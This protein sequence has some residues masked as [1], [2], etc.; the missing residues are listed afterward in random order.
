[1]TKAFR[2]IFIFLIALTVQLDLCFAAKRDVQDP[3]LRE[4]INEFGNKIQKFTNK[5]G[6]DIFNQEGTVTR[7]EFII[8]LYEYDIATQAINKKKLDALE[9]KVNLLG[10]ND[11]PS[12]SKRKEK[13]DATNIV[14][15]I[16]D[17]EPNM[18]MLLDNSLKNSKVFNELQQQIKDKKGRN[19]DTP[20]GSSISRK[21][22]SEIKEALSR[23]ES[24]QRSISQKVDEFKRIEK[25]PVKELSEIKKTLS[26]LQ[27]DYASILKKVD[28]LN[29]STS[30]VER[31]EKNKM[32]NI[33]TEYNDFSSSSSYNNNTSKLVGLS[34]GL[35][36]V[37]ALFI[38]RQ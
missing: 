8:A 12:N 35:S 28:K 17:L 25:N 4:I 18:P 33:S 15:L 26:Q 7:A 19:E 16:A 31:F 11:L 3:V 13:E 38:S 14:R 23:L 34:L 20:K 9:N 24:E 2:V 36:M 6:E 27:L 1:M 10:K 32:K 37:A 29:S 5:Y 30:K 22:P 21:D